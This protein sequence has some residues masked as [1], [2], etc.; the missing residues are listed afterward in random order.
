MSN[1]FERESEGAGGDG[2]STSVMRLI[3]QMF[4]LPFTMFVY[5]M[6][7]FVK[8][9]K[10]MQRAADRGMDVVGGT[11]PWGDVPTDGGHPTDQ[12]V[13]KGVPEPDTPNDEQNE[14][15]DKTTS[16]TG[17][18]MDGDAEANQKEIV[19]MT[20][21]NLSDDQ[22]KLVRYKILFVK[23]DF[24]T[25]FPER[26]ELIYDNMTAE[27]FTA[28]KIAE[29]IQRLEEEL[30]PVRWRTK[31]YPTGRNYTDDEKRPETRVYI[32]RLS[33]DDKKYLR[34]YFEVLDRYV[35]EEGDDEVEVLKEIRDAINS[36]QSK[37]A[38]AAYGGG[39][40]IRK[41]P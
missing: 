35:R 16:S 28:W 39:G 12:M 21:R 33:E 7:V 19:K 41:K 1:R 34:V 18:G 25:A 11:A 26:E 20:D 5:G 4:M 27:A 32:R 15:M 3:G 23:R 24:E 22:L 10:G 2:T 13:E 36:L 17:A 8:T 29:F 40:N 38:E 30:V 9:V 31:N 6:E 14:L 37:E